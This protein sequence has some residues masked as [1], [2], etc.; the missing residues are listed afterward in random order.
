MAGLLVLDRML[1]SD[2]D[3][4]YD[5]WDITKDPWFTSYE[6]EPIQIDL[7]RQSNG[8]STVITLNTNISVLNFTEQA[9]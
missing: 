7:V 2:K 9:N 4:R 8:G 1:T 5:L 3:K 6:L